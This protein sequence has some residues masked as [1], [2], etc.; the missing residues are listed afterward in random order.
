MLR[1]RVVPWLQIYSTEK[2]FVVLFPSASELEAWR[3]LA[4]WTSSKM[5]MRRR[6]RM[7]KLAAT[8]TQA[9]H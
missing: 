6:A 2:S 4:R 7:R 1:S 8:V 5:V 9:R 3:S